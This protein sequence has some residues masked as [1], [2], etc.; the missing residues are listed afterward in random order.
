MGRLFDAVAFCLDCGALVSYEA[1][2]AVALEALALESTDAGGAYPF[3]WKPGAGGCAEIDS[4]PVIAAIVD[5][6][7]RRRAPAAIA[8]SFH[9]GVA[10][11][12]VD[13]AAELSKARGC[14]DVVLSGGVFQNRFLCESI[15]DHARGTQLRFRQ[16]RLVPPNDGGIAYGQLVVG[17]ARLQEGSEKLDG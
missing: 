13:L 4:G 17:A 16:H 1:E 5:D 6:L 2:A 12:V 11:L 15:M 9:R 8:A 3:A 10:S 7:A 14:M